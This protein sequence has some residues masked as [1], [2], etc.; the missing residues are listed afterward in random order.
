[1]KF[2]FVTL[3]PEVIAAHMESSILGRASARSLLSWATANPRDYAYDAHRKVDDTPYGGEPG[4]LLRAEPVALALETLTDGEEKMAV[5]VTEPGGRRFDQSVAKELADC[6]RVVFVC[7]HYEGI[8][9]RFEEECATHVLSIGDFVLT[10]GELPALVM[11]DAVAR[12][13]PGVLGD[14]ASLGADS[15][16]EAGQV[17]APNYTR[18]PTWR[19]RKVPPVLLSGDHAK[20]R[21]WRE[22]QAAER[23]ANRSY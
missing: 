10:G 19:G 8:D 21:A 16:N 22:A 13:V 5:V 15:F 4:M 2:G 20:V 6:E 23:T 9:H 18:P 7:G 17:S 3:F 1:M 12:L 11:A 14:A